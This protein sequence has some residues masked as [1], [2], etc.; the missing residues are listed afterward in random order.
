MAGS[1]KLSKQ[2]NLYTPLEVQKKVKSKLWL[3]VA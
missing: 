3:L 2:G 1:M